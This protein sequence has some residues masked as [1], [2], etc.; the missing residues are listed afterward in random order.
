MKHWCGSN[1]AALA[2][3]G[4]SQPG[5]VLG[6]ILTCCVGIEVFSNVTTPI[7]SLFAEGKVFSFVKM[8][9]SVSINF[10]IAF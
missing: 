9:Q 6:K 1:K 10:Q 4:V 2:T 5:V 3:G 8:G 7:S